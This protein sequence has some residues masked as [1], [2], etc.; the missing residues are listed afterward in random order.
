M[1]CPVAR[2]K[3]APEGSELAERLTVSPSLSDGVT[4]KDT[5]V[6]VLTLLDAGTRSVGGVFVDGSSSP[7]G[8]V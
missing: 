5:G 2:F 1:N 3:L 4:V 7:T 6:P 8:T